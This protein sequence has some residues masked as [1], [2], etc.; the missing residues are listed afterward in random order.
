MGTELIETGACIWTLLQPLVGGVRLIYYIQ[1]IIF[2][3]QYA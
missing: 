3:I 2:C 1:Y